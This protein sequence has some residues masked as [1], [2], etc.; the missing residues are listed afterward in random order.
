MLEVIE[1]CHLLRTADPL[2][3]TGAKSDRLLKK[4]KKLFYKYK[5][6]QSKSYM[7]RNQDE[8]RVFYEIDSGEW[9]PSSVEGRPVLRK[10]V[11]VSFRLHAQT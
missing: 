3:S 8:S 5:A 2:E 7:D 4:G 1:D 10:M 6:K 9:V 11:R